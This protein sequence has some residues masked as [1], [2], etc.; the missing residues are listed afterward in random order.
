VVRGFL[1]NVALDVSDPPNDYLRRHFRNHAP[2]EGPGLPSRS[3]VL[4]FPPD[5]GARIAKF[6]DNNAWWFCAQLLD[7]SLGYAL[8]NKR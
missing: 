4:V 8:I 5:R 2:R 6:F 7:A 3:P 1:E